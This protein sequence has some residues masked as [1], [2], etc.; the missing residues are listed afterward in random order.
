MESTRLLIPMSLR[1]LMFGEERDRYAGPTYD[2]SSLDENPLGDKIEVNPDEEHTE[3]E[4]GIHLH[5]I[6]P[7]V[8]RAGAKASPTGN[9]EFPEVPNRWHVARLWRRRDADPGEG[10]RAMSW[11]VE[12]DA[13]QR[14]SLEENGN[15]GSPQFPMLDDPD[16]Q[17]RYLGRSF[18][19]GST[20]KTS[21]AYLSPTL[22][23]APGLPAFSSYYP[24][25]RNVFGFYDDMRDEK[26]EEIEDA[27]VAYVVCGW[28][29]DTGRDI[30]RELL[31]PKAEDDSGIAVPKG[32]DPSTP[33]ICHGSVGDL[34]WVSKR[35]QYESNVPMED[36]DLAV[37]NTTA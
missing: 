18:R 1:A 35:H 20:P 31:L 15:I 32:L 37:G 2:F 21:E 6:L 9:T 34:P 11:T 19:A 10:L 26:G 8:M 30:A 4:K 25:C 7:E 14:E 22:A 23:V 29:A 3:I 13:L 27:D 36:P 24:D 33:S 28:Y 17:Y 16:T 12:S 5:W